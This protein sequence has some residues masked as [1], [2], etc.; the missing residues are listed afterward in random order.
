M[1]PEVA[2]IRALRLCLC[3]LLLLVLEAAA[4]QKRPNI[5]YILADDLGWNDIVSPTESPPLA[6]VVQ[7][8]L[9]SPFPP[10]SQGYHNVHNEG[11]METPNLDRLASEGIRLSNYYVQPICT[12]TRSVLLSG[13]YVYVR[14][15]TR[16]LTLALASIPTLGRHLYMRRDLCVEPQLTA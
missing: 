13:K 9:R 5:V 14:T 3:L 4:L 8:S 6:V 7:P 16:T 15:L 10:P 2:A 12:P 1:V 11:R